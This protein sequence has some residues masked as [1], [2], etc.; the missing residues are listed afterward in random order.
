MGGS[1]AGGGGTDLVAVLRSYLERMLAGVHGMKA[2]LLDAETTKITS[3][4][5]SQSEILEQEV[6]LVERL[7]EGKGDQLFHLKVCGKAEGW[8]AEVVR[9]CGCLPPGAQQYL[10][11]PAALHNSQA[12]C[13]LR[14]TRENIA[15]I[16]RELRDPR[17]GEY[18]LC[19]Y[20]Q[21]GAEW[22]VVSG[23]LWVGCCSRLCWE[24]GACQG[25]R[26]TAAAD[27][28]GCPHS[29]VAAPLPLLHTAYPAIDCLQSSPIAWRT[30]GCRTLQ[31]W[32]RGRRWHR[33]RSTLATLWPWSPITSW[34]RWHA[35]TWRCS[36]SPGTLATA[37]MR[38]RA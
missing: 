33:C 13:F 4:V 10:T 22:R 31:R 14:P 25:F 9:C 12:V 36:P 29:S 3:T 1:G 21:A 2:L 5:F 17:F 6:Y 23:W 7:E 11:S 35:P 24:G 18:H 28:G 27:Y 8:L 32:M 37:A 30:C 15:R 20:Q 19:E 34:C 26:D 16:R 38:L